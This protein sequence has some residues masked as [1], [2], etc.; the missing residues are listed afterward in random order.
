MGT[1]KHRRSFSSATSTWTDP[2]APDSIECNTQIPYRSR[3]A[4][5]SVTVLWPT[6][7]IQAVSL[8]WLCFVSKVAPTSLSMSTW[9]RTWRHSFQS[10]TLIQGPVASRDPLAIFKCLTHANLLQFCAD[11]SFWSVSFHVM[12][13]APGKQA[14]S[15]GLGNSWRKSAVVCFCPSVTWCNWGLGRHVL[16]CC[17]AFV[18]ILVQMH[19]KYDVTLPWTSQWR[20]TVKQQ[21]SVAGRVAPAL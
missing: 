4:L 6:Q 13:L 3:S 2:K 8:A 1:S 14:S 21:L 10:G 19:L 5:W 18:S 17:A 15:R 16:Q 12:C 11:F 20:Q 9:P 7:T